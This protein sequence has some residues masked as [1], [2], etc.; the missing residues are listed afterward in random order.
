LKTISD[1]ESKLADL[2]QI[3][4]DREKKNL[5]S[6]YASLMHDLAEAHY[7]PALSVFISGFDD[8][9]AQIRWECL[10]M[11]GYHYMFDEKSKETEAIRELLIT[12]KDPLVR[13]CAASV[14]ESHSKWGDS[15]L[16]SALK[17]DT[18]VNVRTAAFESL[19]R[20]SGVPFVEVKKKLD[21]FGKYEVPSWNDLLELISKDAEWQKN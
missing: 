4:A 17:S 18:D 7:Q 19:A 21:K 15:A 13:A 11:A 3:L 9:D 2:T 6:N 8:E 16:E 1:L 12:D 14:L 5:R 20:L 10:M